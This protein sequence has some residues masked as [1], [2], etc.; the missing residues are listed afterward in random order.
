MRRTTTKYPK[1]IIQPKDAKNLIFK[2][3]KENKKLGNIVEAKKWKGFKIYQLTLVERD[4]CPKSCHHWDDC[5]GNNMPFAS[6]HSVK[7]LL[8]RLSQDLQILSERH[9]NGFII[10]LHVLGDFYS[11]PYVAF[12]QNALKHYPNLR[13]FGYTGRKPSTKIGKAI[14]NM[15]RLMPDR[16]VI[17]FSRSEESV[18]DGI[19]YAAAEGFKGKAFFCPEQSGKVES[20][21]DC[22]LCWTT[23]KTVIFLTH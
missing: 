21:A 11:L 19:S 1:S 9:P 14:V 15:N 18:E 13:I 4:T 16:C 12:W 23:K 6:R 17:R 20:C 5:F 8:L 22:A 3:G 7:G 2:P 10:R